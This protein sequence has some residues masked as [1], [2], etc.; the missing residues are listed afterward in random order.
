MQSLIL[1]IDVGLAG[2]VWFASEMKALKD[3]CE[4]FESFPPGHMYSSKQGNQFL[5]CTLFWFQMLRI[6]NECIGN[7]F[8]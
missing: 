5:N 8:Y 3:D 7:E 2:S 1:A 6:Q 4:R